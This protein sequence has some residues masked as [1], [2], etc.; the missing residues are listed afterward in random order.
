MPF[1]TSSRGT[2]AGG[3]ELDGGSITREVERSNDA[4]RPHAERGAR[5]ALSGAW[6][7]LDDRSAGE[8]IPYPGPR[9]PRG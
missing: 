1:W 2:R 5:R 7:T 6:A 3:G 4:S 9:E 8:R